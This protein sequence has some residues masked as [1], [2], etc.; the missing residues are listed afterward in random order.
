MS[1]KNFRKGPHASRAKQKLEDIVSAD[2]GVVPSSDERKTVVLDEDLEGVEFDDRVW[3]YW[4]RNKTFL[5]TS[6]VLAFAVVIGVQ[7][8][9][10]Y[11]KAVKNAL[12]AE[13]AMATTPEQLAKFA[14]ENSGKALAGVAL[15]QNADT[16]YADGK[17]VDAQK[18]Y[19]EAS[20]PLVG[21]V[22]E[23]R[24]LLGEAMSVC[25]QDVAKGAEALKAVFENAKIDSAYKAQAGYLLGLA[26]RQLGKTAE[27]KDVLKKVSADKNSGYYARLAEESL[28]KIN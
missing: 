1:D 11:R 15:L 16:F 26:Y 24:A 14:K 20:K 17:F 10:M 4:K 25:A 5:I 13:Y 9:K 8:F 12:A 3:L 22:L 23:G 21:T 2:A 19:Q 18:T 28:S 7:S 6:I 27:A